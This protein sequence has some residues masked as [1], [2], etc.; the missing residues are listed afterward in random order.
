[1]NEVKGKIVLKIEEGMNPKDIHCTTYQ[2][3]N[4]YQQFATAMIQ[5]LDI[6]SMSMHQKAAIDC[7]SGD[8]V[9]DVCCGRAMILPLIRRHRPN[10]ASYTGVDI[11]PQNYREAFTHAAMSKI[12]GKLS[13]A[14]V[15]PGEPYYPF[16][17]NFVTADVSE[18]FEPLTQSRMTPF[19]YIIYMASIEHMQKEA[20]I[21][22]LVEC[23]R[24]LRSGGRMLLTTPNTRNKEDPYDTQ[25][26][27]HLYE[28]ELDEITPILKSIGFN[29]TNT[30]GLVAKVRGYEEA[31][32]EEYPDLVPVFHAFKEYFPSQWLYS[33][34]PVITPTIA[35][36]V[37]ITLS[38]P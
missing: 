30:F 36:E 24:C 37:A 25:Y 5:T 13:T 7:R 10:I 19:D 6:M 33:L 27:A 35:D 21:K 18:M 11:W 28:W 32:E 20:G 38:K 22:S 34:F 3:R 17:V 31:L 29:I 16:A 14:D 23:F 2:M 9:L 26:A 4:V 15:G 8:K 1:M 12:Q